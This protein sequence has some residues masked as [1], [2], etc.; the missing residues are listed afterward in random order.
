M[1]NS[2]TNLHAA[3]RWNE[4]PGAPTNVMDMRNK[5]KVNLLFSPMTVFCCLRYAGALAK[6]RKAAI[7]FHHVCL[8]VRQFIRMEYL[9]FHW[10]EFHE[11]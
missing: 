7:R 3:P 5:R 2:K 10:K 4:K 8:S 6:L 1:L 9:G 11:I